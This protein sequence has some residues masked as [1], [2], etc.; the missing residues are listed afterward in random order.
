MREVSRSGAVTV[1]V[2][3]MAGVLAGLAGCGASGDRGRDGGATADASDA[4]EPRVCGDGAAPAMT[5]VAPNSTLEF[6]VSAMAVDTFAGQISDSPAMAHT[7]FNLDGRFSDE[8][9]PGGCNHEDFQSALEATEGLGPEC[10]APG[11]GGVDNMLPT[12]AAAIQSI[13]PSFEINATLAR[14]IA[15]GERLLVLRL[16]GVDDMLDD[17]DVRL[18]LLAV[19]DADGRCEDNFTG[20]GRF[21]ADARSFVEGDPAR[22]RWRAHAAIA[23]GR[24]FTL[25]AFTTP[26]PVPLTQQRFLEVDGHAS[27]VRF[28]MPACGESARGNWGAW[29]DVGPLVA[30]ASADEP[31]FAAA[32]AA[33]GA[34]L[35]DVPINGICADTMGPFPTYGGASVGYGFE[36]ARAEVTGVA[37]APSPG[38]CG[39]PDRLDAGS[40]G[41]ADR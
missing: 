6:V 14:S 2:A 38:A 12:L 37:A 17:P 8:T 28:E 5:R 15:R 1:T 21:V 16:T 40:D 3:A 32:F 24:V 20:A 19:F 39:A 41:G 18:T 31:R 13:T 23:H 9:D 34:T 29:V 26:V 7:G 4:S 10:L 11:C 36:L 35:V 25:E 27:Q 30:Q 33:I 22:P